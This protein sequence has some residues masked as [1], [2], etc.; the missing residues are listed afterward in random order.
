MIKTLP[1]VGSHRFKF[2]I[3]DNV[4]EALPVNNK[5]TSVM[6]NANISFRQM[7]KYYREMSKIGLIR[8]KEDG[9]YEITDKGKEFR[10]QYKGII[11]LL[12]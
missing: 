9:G 6:S 5:T 1:L 3:Y 7:K 8:M 10:K 2:E 12:K 4:L 11:A